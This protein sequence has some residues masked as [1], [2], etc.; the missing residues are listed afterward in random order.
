MGTGLLV[1]VPS[2]VFSNR[3]RS[4]LEGIITKHFGGDAMEKLFNRFTKKI[5]MARN[6]PRFKAKVD[7]ML[8]VLKRKVIG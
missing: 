7:D 1:T 5:E 2:E 6:H 8:V 4:T 3:L